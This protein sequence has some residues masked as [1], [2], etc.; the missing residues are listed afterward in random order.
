VTVSGSGGAGAPPTGA[1]TF[2]AK[3]AGS[4]ASAGRC[5]LVVS[6]RSA[7]CTIT[8]TPVAVGKQAVSA[9][10]SGDRAHAQGSAKA[11]VSS[12]RS[13]SVTVTCSPAQLTARGSTT[14]TATAHDTAGG[15]KSTPAGKVTFSA[16]PAGTFGSSGKCTLS[17]GSCKVTY[18]PVAGKQTI[19][20]AYGGDRNHAPSNGTATVT[21]TIAT[22]TSVKCVPRTAGDACTA[23]V[24]NAGLS[25]PT[26]S[27][28]VTFTSSAHG[29]F[30]PSSTCT[31]RGS[32]ASASCSVT[33]QPVAGKQTVSAGYGGDADHGSSKSKPTTVSS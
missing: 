24:S 8:Y 12:P 2:S 14:C 4:F 29:S 5:K 15:T 30:R 28:T 20:A 32:G 26:P 7:K 3:P 27:G 33:Y 6:A 10:Y 13:T 1:V 9:V 18:T 19:T 17:A 22:S 31:L 25:S 23:T 11:A 21:Y 16:L